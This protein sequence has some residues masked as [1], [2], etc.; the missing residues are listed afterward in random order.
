MRRIT[1][2]SLVVFAGLS[3][4][5]SA[6]KYE[7]GPGISFRAK[8]DRISNEWKVT[9]Y[10]VDGTEDAALKKSFT[11][12]GD[13]IVLYFVMGRTNFYT[14]NMDYADGY[15][16]PTKEKVL[17]MNPKD[18]RTYRDILANF[19]ANNVLYKTIKQAGKWS[20]NDKSRKVSF[21]ANEMNDLSQSESNPTTA[22]NADIIMLKNDMLKLEFSIAG[23]KHRITFEP[24]NDEIYKK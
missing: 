5:F 3:I 15:S 20:F 13:S 23:K 14:F 1:K 18:D 2:I 4:L 19:D 6:C 21:G 16:S 12:A 24:K 11:S 22:V 9:G 10:A 7:E 8:R 17:T